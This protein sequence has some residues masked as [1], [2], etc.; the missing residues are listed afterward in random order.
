MKIDHYS[1]LLNHFTS[2]L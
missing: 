1:T 2:I